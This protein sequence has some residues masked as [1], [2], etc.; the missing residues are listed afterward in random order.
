MPKVPHIEGVAHPIDAFVAASQQTHGV[1]FTSEAARATLRRRVS[2]DLTGLPA[3]P[4]GIDRESGTYDDFVDR[5]LASS[6]FGERMAVDWLDAARYA[7]TNG[8]FSDKP[9]QIWL[10]REWV[11]DAFNRNLPFDQFT[12]EQLAGDLLP[13]ASMSQR[14]ATGFNRNHSA[15]N[16][17]GIIDEEF[18]TEYVVDRVDT[19][20]TTWMG[21]TAACAQCHDHKYDPISQR[22]FYQLFAF[23]N[24]L[25]ETGLITKDDPPPIL[26]VSTQEQDCRI[27]ELAVK[28]GAASKE[29][30]SRRTKFAERMQEWE[31]VAEKSLPQPPVESLLLYES[32]NERS[33]M[34]GSLLTGTA[35]KFSRGIRAEAVRFDATQH[36]EQQHT[37]FDADAAWT[38]G[39][40]VLPDGSLSCPLSKIQP[41]DDRRGIEL[42]WQ[43]GRVSVH[44]VHRW[45]MS[46]IEVTTKEPARSGEWHHLVVCYDGCRS[47]AGVNVFVD[48]RPAQLTHRRDSLLGSVANQESLKIGRRDSGLG[49]YGL[50]DELRIIQ[51]SLSDEEVAGWYE[52]ERLRGIIETD[53]ASRSTRETETLQDHF[54]QR[55]GDAELKAARNRMRNAQQEERVMRASIPS[56]LVMQEMAVPRTTHVLQRGQYDQPAEAVQPG[57]PVSIGHWPNTAPMNRLGLAEWI[58]SKD[59]P[60]TARVAVNRLWMQCFGE[61]LVRTAN[62]FG[63]QGEPPTHPELLDWLAVTFRDNGWNV[64]ALLK[65]IVTS[66]TYRQHSGFQIQAGTVVDPQNKWLARGPS[67]RLSSEMIRDQALAVSGLLQRQI[68][69]PSVKPWQPPGLWEEV[70]YNAEETYVPDEGTGQW[71][72]SLY[73]YLKRQA[74]PPSFLAFDGVTREKCTVQRSR[75]NTPLQSLV[76]LNDPTFVEAARQVA[77]LTRTSQTKDDDDRMCQMFQRVLLRNADVEEVRMLKDLLDRQRIRFAKVPE[78]AKALLSVGMTQGTEV[79]ATEAIPSEELAAWTVVAHSLLNLDEAVTRR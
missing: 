7:D 5:L 34:N 71:R 68:G 28:T 79:F 24:N 76:L 12:I 3:E 75:T 9:R 14:I 49:Y 78:A 25:P 60:M 31:A 61:G 33:A 2:F 42:L 46:A 64:K 57:I 27:A 19:T 36:L 22:E 44:L 43:K 77:M 4:L 51:R 52:G 30:E 55:H 70:S 54:I 38:I 74:P 32:L 16:E 69:G 23:F 10:W 17:T 15:N 39:M 58:V 1:K 18:R 50:L 72:R 8:Y 29:F 47:A 62:D 45:G 67:F 59:N 26:M 53:T 6:H 40:W 65:L 37:K 20:M 35:L 48:G 56:T 41:E 63:T 21:L 66:R 13:N 73:T 11:I